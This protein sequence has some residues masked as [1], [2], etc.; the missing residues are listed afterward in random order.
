MNSA[1]QILR[2]L[3][4]E[5]KQKQKEH[6]R[7]IKGAIGVLQ[8]HVNFEDIYEQMRAID[9]VSDL[10]LS[11]ELLGLVGEAKQRLKEAKRQVAA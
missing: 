4:E 8:H 6:Q 7:A 2:W 9:T 11:D 1:E 5:L 10:G 3:C